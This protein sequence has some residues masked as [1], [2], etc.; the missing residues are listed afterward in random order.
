MPEFVKKN[1]FHIFG[2]PIAALVFFTGGIVQSHYGL[3]ADVAEIKKEVR[4]MKSI[5]DK[6]VPLRDEQIKHII[7]RLIRLEE[8]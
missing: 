1:G 4:A 8:K 2:Y 6:Y 5:Q 7:E 3:A